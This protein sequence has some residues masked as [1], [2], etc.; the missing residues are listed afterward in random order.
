[1]EIL[2]YTKAH[3]DFRK[4]VREFLK[5][6]V[7]PFADLWEKDKIVPREIWQKMGQAGFLS[8]TVPK[9]YGGPGLDLLYSI[10]IDEELAKTDQYGL[11]APLHSDIIVPYIIT[12]GNEEQKKKYLP[13]CV[14]GDIITAVAMT[15]PGAGSDLAGMTATA[16]ENGDEIIINGS[17]TFISNGIHCDLVVLALKDP[18]VENPHA[19]MSLYLVEDGTPGFSKGNKLN[20]MGMCSQDTAELFF[21]KCSIP[22]TNLLGEKGKGF[23]MLMAKLQQERLIC[24]VMAVAAAEHM[25][26]KTIS[27]C[28]NNPVSGKP[29]SK[30]QVNQF[31]IA[32]LAT[33]I[34]IGRNF[35]N[36]LIADHMEDKNVIIETSMAKYWTSDM[37][38]RVADKCLDLH[39][40]FATLEKCSLLRNWRDIRVMTIFA[41]TNEIMKGIIAKS[42]GL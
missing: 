12:Y 17:K 33:D 5:K 32:E 34:K 39:G 7:I 18:A 15:E 21:T 42:M 22:K 8:P 13:G 1:M 11:F 35:V 40:R 28:K 4:K 38:K 23:Y 30:S 41:G 14:S 6:E 29:K 3:K 2:N 31:T 9:E 19:A 26:K 24:S 10:I 37:A 16:V 27:F 20:K 25:L 36:K